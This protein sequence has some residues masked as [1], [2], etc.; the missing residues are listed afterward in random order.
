MPHFYERS[1]ENHFVSGIMDHISTHFPLN[2]I[3]LY[4][5]YKT[6]A[7]KNDI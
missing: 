3:K 4:F 1:T 6:L 7:L 2:P 5:E